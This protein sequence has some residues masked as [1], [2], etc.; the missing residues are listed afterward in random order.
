M[1]GCCR[2]RARWLSDAS[3]VPGTRARDSWHRSRRG[4][5]WRVSRTV[6]CGDASKR[7]FSSPLWLVQLA[8]GASMTRHGARTSSQAL[9]Q[10]LASGSVRP[11][12]KLPTGVT[13]GIG[14]LAGVIT[15]YA[16]MPLECVLLS[17]TCVQPCLI[18]RLQCHQ[19]THAESRRE[20]AIPQLV[21]LR[22]EGT[23]GRGRTGLLARRHAATGTSLDVWRHRLH[24]VRGDRARS[25][26]AGG[27]EKHSQ[28]LH[29]DLHRQELWRGH[30]SVG[31]RRVCRRRAYTRCATHRHATAKLQSCPAATISRCQQAGSSAAFSVL[32]GSTPPGK[33]RGQ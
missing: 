15:V 31:S 5:R 21:P 6:S 29:I 10:A 18:R 1:S 4:Y 2:S 12:E 14:A 30:V 27:L 23:L 19:D 9:S 25:R 3:Q 33:R 17:P 22:R 13:F 32:T 20:G 28:L 11:G 24:R 7:Q 8:Q 26:R 16:T